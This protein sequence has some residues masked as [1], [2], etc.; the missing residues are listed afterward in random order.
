MV[1]LSH[2]RCT[3]PECPSRVAMMTPVD[4]REV[5]T[6]SHREYLRCEGQGRDER[7]EDKQLRED[8]AEGRMH[9]ETGTE[10]HARHTVSPESRTQPA[11]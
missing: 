4:T 7:W 3:A 2:S 10:D 1:F 6:T 5:E 9:L 11:R 8:D